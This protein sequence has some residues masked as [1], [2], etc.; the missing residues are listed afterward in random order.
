MGA[1][2]GEKIGLITHEKRVEN[3]YSTGV[4]RKKIDPG[5]IDKIDRGFLSFGYWEKSTKSYLEAATNLIDFFIESS[6]IK[7]V[8]RILNVACGYGAETFVFYDR[9]APESIEGIEITQLHVD[10]AN[11]KAKE[12]GL[13]D[14]IHF[15]YGDACDLNYPVESFSCIFGIEGPAH[16]NPREKFFQAAYKV[17]RRKGELSITD[18][19]LGKKFNRDRK[20]QVLSLGLLAKLWVYPAAN[21]VDEAGYKEKLKKIGWRSIE[22]KSIGSK[23]FPGFAG[24]C[25]KLKTIRTRSAHRG[26]IATIGLNIISFM[27]SY[28][29]KKGLIDYIFVKA[30]KP[31]DRRTGVTG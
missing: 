28:F 20:L 17:L 24:N 31:G 19:I 13:A 23:V 29:Y 26:L 1:V 25:F 9:F 14:K 15:K 30:Q 8:D 27:L 12:L 5:K 7:K 3:F 2:N 11:R 4:D 18:I 22:L 6:R 16:F 10:I 21:W